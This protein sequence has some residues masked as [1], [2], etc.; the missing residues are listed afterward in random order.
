MESI[1]NFL[2]SWPGRIFLMLC[3]SPLVILGLESYFRGSS[4]VNEVANV[5]DQTITRMEYQN[6]INSRR[7]ELLQ[8]GVEPSAINNI[9]L[10]REVLDGLINRAL[11]KNQAQLLGMYVS[12]AVINDLLLKDPQFLDENGQFSN[13]RF[14]F[15]LK[16]QGITK[17]QL[18]NEYRQQLNLMQ[19]Y[20]S[21]AQTA[22]YPSVDINK[23]IVLQKETRDVWLHR[24]PW[25][26][27]QD[28]VQVSNKEIEDYYNE[29]KN[30]LNSRAMVDLS[31]VLLDPKQIPLETV[32]DEEIQAQYDAFKAT[33]I[34][35]YTKKIS[36]ILIT[37]DDARSTLKKIEDRLA[38]GESFAALAAEFSDD[39]ISREKGGDIGTF[40]PDAFGDDGAK[41]AKAIQ[42]LK[43]G[44]VSGPIKTGFGYQ[45]FKVTEVSGNSVPTLEDMREQLAAQVQRQKREQL[46]ADKITRIN[47]MATDGVSIEDIA[48]QEE[49]TLKTLKNYTKVDNTTVLNQ[50]AVIEAAFDDFTIQ[51]ES[52]SPSIKVNKGTLWVQP[53]N[54]RP[55]APLSLQQ[56]SE[57]IKKV[58]VKQKATQKALSDAKRIADKVNNGGMS[59]ASVSFK[60]LGTINRQNPQ[61]SEA[62]KAI[63]FSKDTPKGKLLAIPEATKS[64]ATVI[65]MDA[66]NKAKS[67]DVSET[68]LNQT[69]TIVRQSRGQELFSDY[70]EY[71]KIATDVVENDAIINDIAGL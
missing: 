45:L 65:V 16:Q 6:G 71:L 37:G 61:L 31:Y 70:L 17:D 38:A 10:N 55:V 29:H 14:A 2:K 57:D 52:V 58:L 21:I 23:L 28:Q 32:S 24:L 34:A 11:L 9:V 20:N 15:S 8:S 69:A 60:A 51:D 48:Q 56:A 27:Y 33:Y 49:L 64:G 18:F 50:P 40:N 26:D 67:D 42:G 68:E 36:Q 43:K 44:D 46:V 7:N 39:P 12:D 59:A 54:Y 35:D 41:V 1:R 66:I 19:L 4:S 13:E 22:L 63:V 3:L 5:G 53:A 30:E 25:Q 47:D 62:E